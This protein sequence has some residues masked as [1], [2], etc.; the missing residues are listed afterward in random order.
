MLKIA[1]ASNFLLFTDFLND[2]C[3]KQA[4]TIAKNLTYLNNMA[5]G[6]RTLF[7]LRGSS[8]IA[9]TCEAKQSSVRPN[10]LLWLVAAHLL[11]GVV[12]S[13]I[14]TAGSQRCL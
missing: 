4:I 8:D 3:H 6:S 10:I 7:T 2:Y 13:A 12:L 5:Y 1:N 9:V 14:S 11:S